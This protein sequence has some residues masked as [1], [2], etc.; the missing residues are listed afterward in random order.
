MNK[1][2]NKIKKSWS[3]NVLI[4]IF[5]AQPVVLFVLNQRAVS[6]SQHNAEE[7]LRSPNLFVSESR[8]FKL[9][10][11]SESSATKSIPDPEG[12]D[13]K[14]FLQDYRNGK[15]KEM[16]RAPGWEKSFVTRTITNKPFYWS[17]HNPD[18]D[19]A[20]ASSYQ[21][22]VYYEIE[23][24]GRIAEFFDAQHHAN[25]NVVGEKKE[26]IFLDVGGNIGWYSLLA[27][28]HGASKVYIF[29]PNPANL[30]RFCESLMLN[31]W[32]PDDR[33]QEKI[34]PIAKGVGKEVAKLTLWRAGE[35]N[36]GSFSF[37]EELVSKFKSKTDMQENGVV[38]EIDVITLDSFA[39]SHGWLDDDDLRNSKP[40]IG[41]FKLDVEG[42]EPQVIQGAKEL[43]KSRIVENF[44]MEMKSSM[45]PKDK[46]DIIEI[47]FTSGYDLVIH[48]GWSGPNI[49][50][51]KK[52]DNHLDLSKDICDGKYKENLIFRVRGKD[53]F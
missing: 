47:L 14:S 48:G 9:S 37:S 49:P 29:E 52:Y 44:A 17:L 7:S 4:F 39:R 15:V 22:G 8:N 43:F 34:I 2:T 13:C 53:P 41:F 21:K 26:S 30:V 1:M 23:L 16:E 24:S 25:I 6:S 38:G 45:A 40:S 33:G 27:A 46:R 51:E 10:R 50:V 11:R 36:P 31:D 3:S 18:L 20:R 5:F 32:L 35:S 42:Y 28:A 19:N 12:L